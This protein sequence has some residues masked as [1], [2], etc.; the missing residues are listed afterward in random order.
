MFEGPQ[1]ATVRLIPVWAGDVPDE[2]PAA[3][4]YAVH[5]VE[6]VGEPLVIIERG[7]YL[8]DASQRLDCVVDCRAR[9]WRVGHVVETRS[10]SPEI[11]LAL[12]AGEHGVLENVIYELL[13]VEPK[14]DVALARPTLV[15]PAFS[16]WFEPRVAGLPNELVRAIR[17][18]SITTDEEGNLIGRSA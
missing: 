3:T 1:E 18:L 9:R 4:W 2:V 11:E 8:A 14:E 5:A 6:G 15:V 12:R 16:V 13:S 7:E 17:N 10:Y